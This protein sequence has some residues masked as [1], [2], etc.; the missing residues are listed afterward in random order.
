MAG[1]LPRWGYYIHI[2]TYMGIPQ[3]WMT[4]ATKMRILASD[5]GLGWF[6]RNSLISRR[7]RLPFP[8]I[9]FPMHPVWEIQVWRL[10]PHIYKSPFSL[11]NEMIQAWMERFMIQG[12]S[13]TQYRGFLNQGYP[14]RP[15][16]QYLIGFWHRWDIQARLISWLMSVS[17]YVS[18]CLPPK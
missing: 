17:W 15:N 5:D 6:A 3:N 18:K 7:S 12:S 11:Q 4:L 2:C 8:S 16:H 10:S 1:L 14:A 9:S 13:C